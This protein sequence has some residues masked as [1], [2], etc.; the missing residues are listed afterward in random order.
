MQLNEMQF[1][2]GLLPV[3]GYGSGF[4]R[5]GGQRLEGPLLTLSTG[6]K[7]W[8]GLGDHDGLRALAGDVDVVLFGMGADIAHLPQELEE[9]LE[10]LR[11]GAEVMATPSACRA[12][13]VLLGEGRRVALAALPVT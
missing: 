3:E 5:I 6:P 2:E 8:G 11:I 9:L 12:Y 1:P 7:P 4:F 13:N 10:A